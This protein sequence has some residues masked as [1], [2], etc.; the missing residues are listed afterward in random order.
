VADV[1]LK[2][3]KSFEDQLKVLKER[4]LQVADDAAALN[5]LKRL[6]YYRLSGYFYPLRKT[7]PVGEPG[8]LN[9]FQD[10]AS[11]ELVVQ[12]A[13]FDKRL[14]LIVLYAVES[15]EIALRVAIAHRLGKLDV[16]AH[17]NRD[18]LD[19][20]FV[21]R[22]AGRSRH[23]EW[24]S[25]LEKACQDS[26]EDFIEHHRAKYEG[27]LPIWVAIEVWDFGLLSRFFSGLKRRDQD[28]IATAFGVFDG[29]ALRTWIRT[30]N[31][32]RNVSAHHGRLW[33]RTSTDIPVLPAVERC[34]L[35]E[36]LHQNEH[37]RAKLFGALTCM[38][39]LMRAIDGDATWH[40]KVK[41][42]MQTFPKS[43]LV[44]LEMAGFPGGW[45]ES[46]P[47]S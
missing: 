40:E 4:G 25:R 18:L 47:W 39:V 33:N 26:K 45:E 42:H 28:A 2:P 15:I 6:G 17:L 27:R 23:D 7:R 38:R 19:G 3:F 21:R 11:I 41:A 37:A 24:I 46:A 1:Q 43:D 34:R 44:S 35:I 12:L 29:N 16:E 14:R 10:G 22:N 13:E 20:R 5:A 8:R 32:V 36:V 31:F 30:I 9:E